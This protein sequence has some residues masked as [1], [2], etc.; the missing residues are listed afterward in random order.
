MWGRKVG[1]FVNSLFYS[2]SWIRGGSFDIVLIYIRRRVEI[3][4]RYLGFL[5]MLE[6]I[7][8]II[9]VRV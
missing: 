4:G 7:R 6:M 1:V 2:R 9:I 8:K 3:K 5:V